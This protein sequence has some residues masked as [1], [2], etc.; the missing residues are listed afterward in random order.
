[1][2]T[3]DKVKS[4]IADWKNQG[5]TK[6]QLAV[7]IADACLGWSYV[8][9]G[10]GQI[11]NK[12]NRNSYANRSSCP[13]GEVEQI[14]KKCQILNGSKSNCD[15]CKYYPNG[16]TLFF[17]CRGFTRWVLQQVGIT[18]SGAGATSQY[19]TN[20]NWTEKGTIDKMPRDKVCCVFY[21]KNGTKEHTGLY[22]GD[23]KII[24]C[25]GEVK[26]DVVT[27]RIWTHYAIPKGIDGSAPSPG[28]DLPTI[29]RGS[30]GEYVTLAQTKLIQRGYDLSPYGADGKFGAKTEEAVKA[31]QR[32][33]NLVVDGI[34]GKKSWECL[35]SGTTTTYTV[36]I[37]H[38]SKSVAESIVGTYGGT[39]TAE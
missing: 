29:R 18:I 31:F 16:T 8:W 33:N 11:C 39:M 12:S 21:D 19:N 36:T 4:L 32:D 25:S 5:M 7:K 26:Y 9:G 20:S 22:I 28:S 15:G 13:S 14:K 37:N 35:M 6:A 2:N 38:L 24:H 27:S 30:S 3:Y 1:M 17:D 23:G 34:V 10:A